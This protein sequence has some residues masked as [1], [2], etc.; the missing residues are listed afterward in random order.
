MVLSWFRCV[1]CK[2]FQP[3]EYLNA[4]SENSGKRRNCVLKPGQTSGEL[5]VLLEESL[6]L[7]VNRCLQKC[8][9]FCVL[10]IQLFSYRFFLL[11]VL[12]QHM[13]TFP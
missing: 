11:A 12:F 7:D 13:F 1:A 6:C 3:L 9:V 2:F 4:P 8:V 10:G 5:D